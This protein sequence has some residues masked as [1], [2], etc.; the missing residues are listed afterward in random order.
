MPSRAVLLDRDGVI[1]RDLG[2]VGDPA[3]VELL[4]L[5]PRALGLLRDAGFLLVVVTNQSG[6]GRG[7]FSAEAHE[8]V[9]R[10]MEELLA[11]H[12][13]RLDGYYH[14]PHA[15]W[16]GCQCRKPNGG[17][18]LKAAEELHIDLGSSWVVG[19]KMSDLGLA[20]RVGSRGILVGEGACPVDG[21]PA[22]PDLMGAARIILDIEGL[23]S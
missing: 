20:I 16:E 14:C 13:V 18:A 6:I 2:Y 1:M 11:A 17:M 8:A 7:L 9:R 21:F 12:G 15:P 3:Q 5:V 19:D 23:S 10:R 4:P 22:A